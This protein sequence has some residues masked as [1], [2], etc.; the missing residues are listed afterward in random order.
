M[1]T[2]KPLIIGQ[3]GFQPK[4]RGIIW[5]TSTMHYD[6]PSIP[7]GYFKPLDFDTK[8]PSHLNNQAFVD[9]LGDEYPDQELRHMLVDGFQMK[10]N[11]PLQIVILP[12]LLSLADAFDSADAELDRLANTDNNYLRFI[13]G[14]CGH[15]CSMDAAAKRCCLPDATPALILHRRL[16]RSTGRPAP[17]RR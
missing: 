17:K 15:I 16:T 4:A 13:A 9:L 1:R 5:D 14:N 12:H 10:I 11:P 2:A 7:N 8:P 6:D 3:D